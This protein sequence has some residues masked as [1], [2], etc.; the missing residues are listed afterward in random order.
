MILL[1]FFLVSVPQQTTFLSLH[2][3]LPS[4]KLKRLL[5]TKSI[6][7]FAPIN[8]DRMMILVWTEEFPKKF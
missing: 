7:G 8:E 5:K 1:F 6:I 3:S 4:L 2:T